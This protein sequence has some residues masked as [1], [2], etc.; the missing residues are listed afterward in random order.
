[1]KQIIIKNSLNF[2]DQREQKLSDFYVDKFIQKFINT[3]MYGKVEITKES[4]YLF[5]HN[6]TGFSHF[7]ISGMQPKN[8]REMLIFLQGAIYAV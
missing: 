1:M 7:N 8:N 4:I 3:D 2:K 6:E 5:K